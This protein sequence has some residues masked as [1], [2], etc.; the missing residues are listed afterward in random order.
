M[1]LLPIRPKYCEVQF[2]DLV[3]KLIFLC[4]KQCLCVTNNIVYLEM[5]WTVFV[6]KL[7]M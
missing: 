4:K 5:K 6:S 3:C 7:C 2:T 1:C